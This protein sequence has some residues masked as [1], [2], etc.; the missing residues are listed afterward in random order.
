[1]VRIGTRSVGTDTLAHHPTSKQK[2]ADG[3]A[4]E[5]NI[6][7]DLGDS[8]SFLVVRNKLKHAKKDAFLQ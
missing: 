2:M 3:K 1:M 6:A 5:N 7:G 8:M 4:L